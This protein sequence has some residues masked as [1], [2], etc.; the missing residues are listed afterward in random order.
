MPVD[1]NK[2]KE[3]QATMFAKADEANHACYIARWLDPPY[4]GFSY[5]SYKNIDAWLDKYER[6]PTERKMYGEL[7][8][9]GKPVCEYYDIDE[10]QKGQDI[11]E[12]IDV[13]VKTRNEFCKTIDLPP[14]RKH[15]LLVTESCDDRKF[16]LHMFVRNKRHFTTIA[17]H[18]LFGLQFKSWLDDN[19]M[20]F[21]IDPSVYNKNSIFRCVG[22]HKPKQTR[23]VKPTKVTEASRLNDMKLTFASHIEEL[24]N[25]HV[26]HQPEKKVREVVPHNHTGDELLDMFWKLDK[27]R[28]DERESWRN[29][30]WLGTKE[31]IGRDDLC[32]LSAQSYKHTDEAVDVII[33][34]FR[35]DACGITM[36]SLKF[37]LREDLGDEEYYK[38]FPKKQTERLT[39]NT[40][41]M[42]HRDVAFVC[43][44]KMDRLKYCNDLWYYCRP[45][46][47]LWAIVK[48][49]HG[50]IV[51]V[52]Q[53]EINDLVAEVCDNIKRADDEGRKKL[54]EER[55]ELLKTY[56][57]VAGTG[58]APCVMNYLTEYL[59]HEK[60]NEKIDYTIGFLA[61]KN[62][63]LDLKTGV[64][65]NGLLPDDY[66]SFTLDFDYKKN[67]VDKNSFVWKQFKKVLNNNDEHLDYF[68]SLVGHSFTGESALVKAMYF[69]IDG[70]GEGKGDN[71]KTFLFNIF[72]AV[73]GDYVAKPTSSLLEKNNA[74]VHKQITGLKGKR[75]IFME[76]FP[77][78]AINCDLMKELGDG[79]EMNNEVMFGTMEKINII[80]MF[81]A[82][83][84]H[85]PKLDADE[86][87][88]YNRYKEV[89]F[90]SHFDRTGD[91]EEEN[92]GGL[93][94]IADTSLGAKIVNEYRDEVVGLILQYAMRFYTS[95]IPPTPIEFLQAEQQTKASN[96]DFLEWFQDNCEK[97]D[98]DD[99]LAFRKIV[100]WSGIDGGKVRKGMA[101]LGYKYYSQESFGK[102]WKK[103]GFLGVRLVGE[104]TGGEASGV[105]L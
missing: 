105:P 102:K 92:E 18:K 85:T 2:K 81:F 86:S 93:E 53:D 36:G 54:E 34:G 76:E 28:W 39:A 8:R 14:I 20:A 63:I 97:G 19:D 16:S 72:K 69:M 26:I 100:E 35:H 38:L 56:T 71:G 7:L 96:D 22:S 41:R 77:Q 62:G 95:G 44:K 3:P 25:A 40:L 103:G 27:G 79:G 74:K 82:L 91:R 21:T 61:F 5:D 48:K 43:S 46:T 70:S 45:A 1:M 10:K 83:S 80:G 90:K 59:Y 98:D 11:E 65:R 29:L 50:Y 30:I 47:N 17:D 104:M 51:K 94:F 64:F 15:Q 99:R 89:S 78:K 6:V 66:I 13:F 4:Q 55:K 73:M 58:Y 101:R 37:F 75:F 67:A 9:E 88:G 87:A 84:N 31:G 12:W 24:S 23:I 49:P 57:I 52:I 68:M 60:F 32:E 42:G 33:D